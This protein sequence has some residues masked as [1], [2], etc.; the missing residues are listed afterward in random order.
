LSKP[1]VLVLVALLCAAALP[2]LAGWGKVGAVSFSRKHAHESIRAKFK[3]ETLALTAQDGDVFC[4]DVQARFANNRTRTILHNVALTF[5]ETVKV[6]LPG[7]VRNVERLNFDCW[8]L[9]NPR[10][11]VDVAVNTDSRASPETAIASGNP[12]P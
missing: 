2:A 12:R 1:G 10:T 3:A 7:G 4:G 6:D 9:Y 8:S 11:R 5:D